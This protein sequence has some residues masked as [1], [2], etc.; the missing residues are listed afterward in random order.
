[1]IKKNLLFSILIVSISPIFVSTS[2]K[3]ENKIN[4]LENEKMLYTKDILI[5]NLDNSI[6]QIRENISNYLKKNNIKDIERTTKKTYDNYGILPNGQQ[7]KNDVFPW[8]IDSE[9]NEYIFL[10][11]QDS[12]IDSLDKV[13][14]KTQ[15]EAY[16][17]HIHICGKVKKRVQHTAI[18]SAKLITKNLIENLKTSFPNK[19]FYVY[20]DCD[21]NDHIILRF[22]QLWENEAPYYNVKDFPNIEVYKIGI[23]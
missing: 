8:L 11:T 22:H 21:F 23:K 10:K 5:K 16:E 3:N 4:I 2:C 9:N 1:M 20:L 14:D 17:N 7:A 6:K 18:T 13:S 15:L 12:K 19:S